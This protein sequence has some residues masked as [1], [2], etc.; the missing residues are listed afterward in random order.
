LSRNQRFTLLGL[1]VVVLV[2]AFVVARSGGDSGSSDTK[3]PSSQTGG[4]GSGGATAPG[5]PAV[6]TVTVKNAAPVGG[7]K[8]LTFK[9]ND[10]IVFVVRSDTADEV[11]FHGYDVAKDVKAGGQV[12]FDV[13]ATI[14]GRFEVELENHKTQ[15][16]QVE[17]Q[18]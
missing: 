16:A 6:Q 4:S 15:I 10:Q 14:E 5:E 8:R 3:T 13:K 7:V 9:H 11:H 12:R 1:A 18:P 17:V 2:V